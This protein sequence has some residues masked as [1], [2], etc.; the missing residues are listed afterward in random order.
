LKI[1]LMG[2]GRI[3]RNIYRLGYNNSDFD[4]VGI[5]DLG[6]P[7]TLCYLLQN[8]SLHGKFNHKVQCA[9]STMDVEGKS[10]EIYPG[11]SPSEIPWDKI[12]I[13][14][15]I[16]S[17]GV[18]WDDN[19]LKHYNANTKLTV[20]TSNTN[21]DF[22]RIV[23]PGINDGSI[24]KDDSII[25]PSSSTTQALALMLDVLDSG[26]GIQNSMMTTV[27]AYT[28][29][30]PLADDT[31]FR[32]RRSRSAVENII[33]NHSESPK[34]IE[35]I[36]PK[37]KGKIA[38]IALNVPTPNGSCVDLTSELDRIPK[39]EE[40]N[41]LFKSVSENSHKNIIG[42]TDDPIV[43]T[44]AVG[45]LETMVFDSKATMIASNHFLKTICWYDNGWGF[46][47]RILEI[48]SAYNN[49]GG[50]F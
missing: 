40:V 49:L 8:D 20:I 30:Q 34:I 13:D 19:E 48:I 24:S 7:D 18:I 21:H 35:K 14:V 9:G 38:G 6:R 44:D 1:F 11:Y 37:F 29:D 10:I 39:I 15:V 22:D 16:D 50:K 32:T 36:L 41:E 12:D 17:T 26:F 47:K 5:S 42:F 28:A 4:F 33:P 43:S 31:K 27:H 23:I 45:I 25:S 46:S 2:F 3:G